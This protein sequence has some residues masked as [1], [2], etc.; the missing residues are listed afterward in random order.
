MRD[1][2]DCACKTI[3]RHEHLAADESCESHLH[4]CQVVAAAGTDQVIQRSSNG[5]DLIVAGH[6]IALAN[7]GV[8]A[9][10]TMANWQL[11]IEL[12]IG[13]RSNRV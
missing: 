9:T 5:R 6:G 12:A 4:I 1:R 8:H 2:P 11:A 10:D 3:V 7:S 13:E